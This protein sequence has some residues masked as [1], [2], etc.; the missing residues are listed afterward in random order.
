MSQDVSYSS[1]FALPTATSSNHF[2][3][4]NDG[5]VM[6]MGT[7]PVP[8]QLSTRDESSTIFSIMYLLDLPLAI[9]QC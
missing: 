4:N 3:Q 1:E 9:F 6:G 8:V 7:K 2:H 5:M